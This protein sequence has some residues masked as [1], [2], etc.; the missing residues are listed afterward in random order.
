MHDMENQSWKDDTVT[1]PFGRPVLL[2]TLV[3]VLFG[4]FV[5][6]I[7][8]DTPHSSY[9]GMNW[10]SPDTTATVKPKWTVAIDS[11][12]DLNTINAGTIASGEGKVFVFQHGRLL[13]LNAKTGKTLWAYGSKM[14]SPIAYRDGV[15]YAIS[16]EGVLHAIQ[17]ING[18]KKWATASRTSGIARLLVNG[19]KV[20]VYNGH[21]RAFDAKSGTL[22]WTDHFPNAYSDQDIQFAAGKVLVSTSFSGAYTYQTL[23]AFNESNGQLAWEAP[24][25]S[26][27]L[28]I[29]GNQI[30]VQR[31]SNLLDQLEKTTLDTID[32]LSGKIVKTVEYEENGQAWIDSGHVYIFAAGVVYAYPL[33]AV[34]DQVARDSYRSDSAYKNFW[35]GGPDAGRI[36]FTDGDQITG[37]KLVNKSVV[38]Y[39]S[40]GTQG[41]SIARFDTFG[42]GLYVAYS[43]G[44][45]EAKDLITAKRVFVIQTKGRVFGPTLREDGM[46]IVQSQGSVNAVSEPALLK[47]K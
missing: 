22:L 10:T 29:Q 20:Y 33:N 44:R 43:D 8:A 32:T 7:Y 21:I 4:A 28:Y 47:A 12:K 27:P 24:N 36:L 42:N 6:P 11:P 13:A 9:Q 46:I 16:E 2:F 31:T 45:L 25:A 38:Y 26:A 23:L 18:K 34:P 14:I 41:T 19:D 3:F 30:I 40:A 37:S 5:R 39:G 35:A 15:V 1:I 17:A